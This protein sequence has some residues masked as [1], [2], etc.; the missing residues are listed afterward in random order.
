M[1]KPNVTTLEAG[2]CLQILQAANGP[3][4]AAELARKLG[5]AGCR[6]TQRR[7][8]REI[9]KHLKDNSGAMIVA[10]L[11]SGYWLT[12]DEQLWRDYLLHRQI[13]AK[14]IL[15]ETH[16]RKKMLADPSGQGRLFESR[17]H[18]GVASCIV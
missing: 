14:R 17:I 9:V 4:V 13:D 12:E 7:R 6:E 3:I 1:T 8:V 16:K 2:R 15:G 11:Q 10:S 18:Y 5:L